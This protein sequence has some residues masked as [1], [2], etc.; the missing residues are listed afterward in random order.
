MTRTKSGD[1]GLVASRAAGRSA[2][3]KASGFGSETTARTA[4]TYAAEAK[5]Y[6]RRWGRRSY[7]QPKLL[8]DYLRT[9]RRGAAVL[10]LGSGAGQDVRH[11]R[12]KGYR[13]VGLDL[14]WPLLAYARRRSRRAALVQ[15][16]MRYP[17]FRTGVFD[18]IWAAASLIHLPKPVVRSTLRTLRELVLPG[19]MLAA[20]FVHGRS[21]GFL[22]AGWI[23]GRFFSR[24]H[25]AA[26]ESAVRRAGWTIMRLETVANRERKGR[27]LNLLARRPAL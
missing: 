14:T 21:S 2:V 1:P 27:W 7:R 5:T 13:V 24:W 12:R 23:P 8:R 26:L 3:A 4:R 11:L 6:L 19:G 15:A 20:T 9:R 17:P 25:K 10:D 22:R 18:G 16:D